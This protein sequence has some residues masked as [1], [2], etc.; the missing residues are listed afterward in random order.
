VKTPA[1]EIEFAP[2]R[3][4]LWFNRPEGA[5]ALDRAMF[6]ALATAVDLLEARDDISVIV[7]RGRGRGFCA[8]ANLA[9]LGA[10]DGQAAAESSLVWPRLLDRLA[11]LP[12]PL[13]AALHGYAL[14][15]GFLIS[16]YCDVRLAVDGT[17]IG[18]PQ[19]SQFWLPPW[20]LSRLAAWLGPARAQ[21]MLLY[22]P[23]LDAA[24]ALKHGLV[25]AVA[26]AAEFELLV[27]ETATRLAACRRDVV[28]EARRFFTA[29][30]GRPHSDWDR[31]SAEGFARTFGSPAAQQ[32]IRAILERSKTKA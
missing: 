18:F 32:A 27:E 31:L 26:P 12:I 3:A 25:E 14:G 13:V 19:A 16:L 15:G 8:G 28:L 11:A 24:A 5:N 22:T 4:T 10:L 2:P 6:D 7:L 21:Q 29:L 23:E 20:G 30:A 1:I 17:R 9:E